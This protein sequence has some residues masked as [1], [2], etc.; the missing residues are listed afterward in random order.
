MGRK[1]RAGMKRAEVN[2]FCKLI[3]SQQRFIAEAYTTVVT[4]N[5]ESL[6]M[7]DTIEFCLKKLAQEMGISTRRYNM[8]N[9][10]MYAQLRKQKKGDK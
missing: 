9:D 1:N 6:N 7:L 8:L 2:E 5:E 3:Q 10:E 4:Y